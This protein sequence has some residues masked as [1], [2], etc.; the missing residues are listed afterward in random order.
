MPDRSFLD[1]PFFEPRHRGARATTLDA[2]A[3][4]NLAR[5]PRRHR[6][7][8][9]RAGR[10][11]RRGDGWLDPHR[12][13]PGR[14]R[15][16]RRPHPLPDP[17]DARPPRRPR[18][19]RLR[20]AGPRHRRDLALRHARA[21]PPLA[22]PRPAPG[23]AIAAFALTEP[24]LRLRR[25]R[26]RHDRH[27]RRR[28]LRPRRREDLDLQ[29]R[30]R[31]PLHRLRPHRRGARR[32]AASPPSSSP[33]TPPASPSPSGS[34]PIAPHPLARLRFDGLRLPADAL[35]GKPGDGF[36]IA[37]SVLDV[38]RSTVAAA[39]LGFARRALDESARPRRPAASSSAR[40]WPTCRWSR[41][42]SPTWR[43]TSTPPRCSPTA[44][45]G[46]RTRAPPASPARRRW[47]SS[48]PPTARSA[49]STPRSSS[50]AA[51]ASA[52]ARRR[53][54]YREI[55]ALRIYEGASD[56]QKVVIAR[57]RPSAQCPG[58][59]HYDQAR[60]NGGITRERR[61]LR[62]RS[63]G[64][65]SASATSRRRPAPRPS[66]SRRTAPRGQFV[67]GRTST[68]TRTSSSSSRKA[69]LDAEARRPSGRPPAPATS[70][71][72]P[73]GVPA[74]LLQQVRRALPRA[75]SGS[76]RPGAAYREALRDA[77]TT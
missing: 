2:W 31:R 50:T 69:E 53:G 10:G 55:R 20:H 17:R 9:P 39:A 38:F 3:A 27:P 15:R 49:S 26:H 23:R 51:T 76:R 46:P 43:S 42:T 59:D 72:M 74:R 63:S 73:R 60:C 54:L 21:A 68:R 61:G 18:R 47:P 28:R 66:P 56:V 57:R 70:S 22:R 77:F 44:P 75:R 36:K 14:A 65:S 48:S 33:P 58:S 35:I 8:L 45:P 25:R 34:R 62:R 52:R 5:R 11:A 71:G 12:R 24:Q 30:H 41:A 6:R 40:R 13:R 7:R 4:A 19:L 29:R 67:P 37:M 16:A 32:P 1:W 64:T